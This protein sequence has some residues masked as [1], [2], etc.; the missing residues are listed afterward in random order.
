MPN[1]IEVFQLLP[2]TVI[3][4]NGTT[5]ETLIDISRFSKVEIISYT[6]AISGTNPTLDVVIRDW[7]EKNSVNFNWVVLAQITAT[8]S[9]RHVSATT[10]RKIYATWTIGGTATPT[11][12]FS[13]TLYGTIS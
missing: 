4:A 13:L 12:T 2:P 10:T 11:F 7:E 6:S 8:G 3:T 5:L 1:R 9:N